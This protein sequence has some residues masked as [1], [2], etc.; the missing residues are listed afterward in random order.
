MLSGLKLYAFVLVLSWSEAR[1]HVLKETK[2]MYRPVDFLKASLQFLPFRWSGNRTSRL[3]TYIAS[4]LTHLHEKKKE[5]GKTQQKLV[6]SDLIHWL[7]LCVL[8]IVDRMWAG[9]VAGSHQFA[10]CKDG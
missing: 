10:F 6:A 1:I 8:D 2:G 7:L 9:Y 3:A 4:A 5:R